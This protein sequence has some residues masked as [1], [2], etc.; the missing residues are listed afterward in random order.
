MKNDKN[1]RD[2]NVIKTSKIAKKVLVPTALMLGGLNGCAVSSHRSSAKRNLTSS[3]Q[4][5]QNV[6]IQS[7]EANPDPTTVFNAFGGTNTKPSQLKNS[8]SSDTK[9]GMSRFINDIKQSRR[10]LNKMTRSER[11][12]GDVS[13]SK[14]S[15]EVMPGSM[16][17]VGKATGVNFAAGGCGASYK[18]SC[19]TTITGVG[20]CEWTGSDLASG[21][22]YC[23]PPSSDTTP[24]VVNSITPKNGPSPSADSIQFLVIFD[25]SVNGVSTD[26]FELTGTGTASGSI[27]SVSSSSGSA[28]DVTV[29]NISGQGSLRLDLKGST[30]ITDDDG[31]GNGNNGSVAAYS[32]GTAHNVDRIAPDVSAIVR[33]TPSVA[34]TNSDTLVWTISFSKSVSNINPDDFEV[35]GTTA[36]VT[37]V[38][39]AS[40]SSVDITVSGGD[41]AGYS[42]GVALSLAAGNN[43]QDSSGN[44][45]SST[46]PTGAAESYTLDNDLPLF[47]SVSDSSDSNYKAGETVTIT[48]D[49]G[50]TGL[51]VTANLS[52]LDSDFSA[53]QAL[54]DN[55]DN[56]YS[57]QTPALDAGGNMQEGTFAITVTATDA[58]G[59]ENTD[60]S[61]SLTLDKTPPTF[62]SADSVPTDNAF[63]IASNSNLILDFSENVELVSGKT[64][65]IY[66]VTNGAVLETYTASSTTA[67]TGSSSGAA[68]LSGDKL[69]IN[70]SSDFSLGN[71]YAVT[72]DSTTLQDPSGNVFAGISDYI[73]YNFA[74]Q[75]EL[76]L[77]VADSNIAE[78][79]GSTTYTVALIDGNGN[80][81]NAD[82]NITVEMALSGTAVS[83]SDYS[84]SGLDGSNQITIA[85]GDTSNTFT[86][87]SSSDASDDDGE[88]IIIGMNSVVSG[89]ATI[90][91]VASQT[92]TINQNDQP[93]IAGLDATPTFSEDGSAV[94]IDSDVTVS[95][96]ELDALNGAQGNYD[97][98]SITIARAGG[99][100][101]GDVFGNGGALGTL[102]ESSSFTYNGTVVGTVT[103]NSAGTLT[104][105]F[106]SNATTAVVNS[107]LQNIT[108]ENTNDD[109]ASTV[110]LSFVFNDGIENSSAVQVTASITAVNDV[111]TLTATGSSPAFVEGG[112]AAV[113]FSSAVVSTVEASQTLAG[114]VITVTNVADATNEKL[115]IDGASITLTEGQSGS[116]SNFSYVVSVV[117]TTATVT[118]TGGTLTEAQ[119][120]SV[121]DAISY[122]NDSDDPTT[123]SNRVVTITSISETGSVNTVA[124]TT[125]SSTVSVNGVDDEPIVS[126]NGL[127]PTYAEGA[128]ASYV[129]SSASVNTVESSQ[130]I[131]GA[132]FTISGLQDGSE[133]AL[134]VDATEITLVQ[135]ASG[136]TTT[137][138][139]DYS[140]SVSGNVA[141][142]VL[143][144]VT[145]TAQ[146]AQQLLNYIGYIHKSDDPTE[147]NRIVTLTE[148]TDSGSNSGS[149]DNLNDTLAIASTVSVSAVDDAPTLNAS[150]LN[151]TF[152]ENGSPVSIFSSAAVDTVEASQ[153][154]ESITWQ[155]SGVTNSGGEY[156][157]VDGTDVSLVDGVSGTTTENSF[158]YQVS[159]ISSGVF[160]VS[161]SKQDTASN[162]QTLIDGIAYRNTAEN[163]VTG[164][165]TIS[166]T[167]LVDSGDSDGSNLNSNSSLSLT[168]TLPIVGVNDDPSIT[169]GN[170]LSTDEDNNQTLSFNFSDVDGDTVTATEKN[171]P[172]HAQTAISGTDIVY[173]PTANYNGSDSFVELQL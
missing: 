115:T 114:L 100:Q 71:R 116:T 104:L 137:N 99:A 117:S 35:S 172:S 19:N 6:W 170:Q 64:F 102:V 148:V 162:Y 136:T 69:T 33:K 87:T 141:T 78:N 41:L 58:V 1:E 128:A 34:D 70:P 3:K 59:N 65:A 16:A 57:F 109:P 119:M 15:S 118:L 139:I 23:N 50:E 80:A 144:N 32:G 112:A 110:S 161:V 140:V 95:D 22:Q 106:N 101:N 81:Y 105:T 98:S 66:D 171:A 9:H 88:T 63:G 173:T 150:A 13:L 4:R 48:V 73:T 67:A 85:T 166:I 132:T 126:A 151:S 142:V 82:E 52:V 31:N 138:L 108:Y 159:V 55:N 54:T 42:G 111:P 107:V 135:G 123:A 154:I 129:Y 168:S 12:V 37:S 43:L 120:Q 84:V 20:V 133:E 39:A 40:G 134:V 11:V 160:A 45:L 10:A 7:T 143:S 76:K 92:V 68:T 14:R 156:L 169:I 165:R 46:T 164:S 90:G 24:P 74:V 158:A 61:L 26:A 56:T 103:T 145:G 60:N 62:S 49:L 94:V 146:L 152:T 77:T 91:A 163:I 127:S 125:I 27:D 131:T 130:T 18:I 47:T 122:Q 29:N 44:S 155:V 53:T 93:V 25:E 75:P 153:L 86:V 5:P 36:M 124:N 147:G 89:T 30:N 72:I 167:N 113:L 2:D 28:I 51:N 97:G 149:N 121:I 8:S 17:V 96:T 157:V 38:S 79:S 21:T 83:A